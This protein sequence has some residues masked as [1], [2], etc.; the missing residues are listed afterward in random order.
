MAQIQKSSRS[1]ETGPTLS[2]VTEVGRDVLK[3]TV[4]G[5]VSFMVLRML[6]TAFVRYWKATHPE[7]PPPPTV[8]FGKLPAL[9]YPNQEFRPDSF[10]LETATNKLPEYGDRAKVFF[11]PFSSPSL[12][13]DEKV[14]DIASRFGFESQP[15]LI[16]SN[17]YRWT[18]RQPLNTTLEIDLKNYNFSLNSDYLSRIELVTA[19][20]LPQSRDA[21]SRVKSLLSNVDLL[22]ADVA[23]ASGNTTYLKALGGEL[24]EAVSASDADFIRVDLDRI[25]VD[26]IYHMFT[27]DGDVGI[28]S[29]VVTG[30]YERRNSVL[31][32]DYRYQPVNYDQAETYP[33]KTA[34]EAWQELKEGGG[35][36]VDGPFDQAVVRKIQFGY[37]DGFEEQQFLQPIYVFSGDDNFMAYVP[38]IKNEHLEQEQE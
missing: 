14:R 12:L 7:P 26:G 22:A 20:N 38:A 15:E 2:E 19:E 36:V 37:Y 28:I 3:Y 6:G 32:M 16:S 31:D 18:K 24:L 25:P 33:I 5:L 17:Y 9:N 11:M 8:G 29:A 4:I 10:K 23:T 21:I 27:P 1:E 30:A 13:A 34:R 35:Y